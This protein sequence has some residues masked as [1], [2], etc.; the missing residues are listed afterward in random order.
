MKLR[1]NQILNFLAVFF[2]VGNTLIAMEKKDFFY[3]VQN[4]KTMCRQ[5]D[6]V[7]LFTIEG[8]CPI[9][10][11]YKY[12]PQLKKDIMVGFSVLKNNIDVKKQRPT[13]GKFFPRSVIKQS[14]LHGK[15]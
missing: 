10:I 3:D 11:T 13:V 8:K 4:N 7:L 12:D 5:F 9:S 2:I 6:D 14:R 1:L 15:K